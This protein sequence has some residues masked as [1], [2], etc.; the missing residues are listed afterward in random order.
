MN[1]DYKR[2]YLDSKNIVEKMRL[3]GHSLTYIYDCLKNN[4]KFEGCYASFYYH[5]NTISSTKL[6]IKNLKGETTTKKSQ[7]KDI[8]KENI[9]EEKTLL[10]V[11]QSFKLGNNLND[12]KDLK[13]DPYEA[14]RKKQK[15]VEMFLERKR[16]EKEVLFQKGGSGIEDEEYE[17]IKKDLI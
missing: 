7:I 2:Q 16:Q 17:K 12:I 5:Y 13:S 10:P 6:S 11:K 9:S 3:K 1:K 14:S 8:P 4:G 15:E